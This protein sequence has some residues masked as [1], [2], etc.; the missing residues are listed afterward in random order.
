MAAPMATA[1]IARLSNTIVSSVLRRIDDRTRL[2]PRVEIEMLENG[3]FAV[4][5]VGDAGLA[6][7]ALRIGAVL[8]VDDEP[9]LVRVSRELV[10]PM[11]CKALLDDGVIVHLHQVGDLAVVPLL[12][13]GEPARVRGVGNPR[14]VGEL[15]RVR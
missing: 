7:K 11:L 5:V 12:R 10:A 13:G 6:V 8:D 14:V 2:D 15:L 1:R 9:A 4:A 3:R